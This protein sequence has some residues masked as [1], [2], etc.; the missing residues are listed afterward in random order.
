MRSWTLGRQNYFDFSF[1]LL[2]CVPMSRTEQHRSYNVFH[3]C[4]QAKPT[5]VHTCFCS[6]LISILE[7]TK[8]LVFPVSLMASRGHALWFL[9]IELETIIC[10]RA[11]GRTLL[12]IMKRT[13]IPEPCFMPC[14]ELQQPFWDHEVKKQR[15]L[16]QLICWTNSSATTNLQSP[17]YT[18]KMNSC[19]L[20]ATLSVLVTE[21]ISSWYNRRFG[22]FEN[23]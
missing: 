2:P 21:I 8:N 18:R 11:S 4:W 19:P 16:V 13:N 10:Q 17:C 5:S 6:L 3:M 9:T 14:L 12:Y 15:I 22:G 20:L 23:F 1:I 7:A